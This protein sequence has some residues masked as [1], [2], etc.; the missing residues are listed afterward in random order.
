M[1]ALHKTTQIYLNRP[2]E[3]CEKNFAKHSGGAIPFKNRKL[4]ISM[5]KFITGIFKSLRVSIY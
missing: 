1:T 2:L 5:V 3:F 4:L